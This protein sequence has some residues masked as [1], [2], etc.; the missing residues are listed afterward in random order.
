MIVFITP[1]DQD[2]QIVQHKN[3]III[4]NFENKGRS[5]LGDAHLVYIEKHTTLQFR[6][7]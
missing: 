7:T 1:R 5:A 3:V 4:V 6:I 2:K